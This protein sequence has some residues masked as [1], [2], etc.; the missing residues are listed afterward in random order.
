[1]SKRVY[2]QDLIHMIQKHTKI[3]YDSKEYKQMKYMTMSELY[4]KLFKLKGW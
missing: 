3:S 4:D 1:M 2:K